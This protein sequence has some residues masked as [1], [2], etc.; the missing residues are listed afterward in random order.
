MAKATLYHGHLMRSMRPLWMFK[1]IQ[2]A[3]E[4][5]K[6]DHIPVFELYTFDREKVRTVKPDWYLAINPNGK[7]PTYVDEKAGITMRDGTAIS[8][9]MLQTYD[10][11]GLLFPSSQSFRASF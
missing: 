4:N 5:R 7:V 2:L 10:V 3:Y 1:E 9:F 11:D 6:K 8:L